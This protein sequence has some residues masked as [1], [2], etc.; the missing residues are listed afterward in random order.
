MDPHHIRFRPNNA[1]SPTTPIRRWFRSIAK[2]IKNPRDFCAFLRQTL[3]PCYHPPTMFIPR[4]WAK[5]DARPSTP[6]DGPPQVSCWK[7]SNISLADAQQRAN[8]HIVELL[9]KL[10]GG[11]PLDH[12]QYNYRPLR[13][14]IIQ[15]I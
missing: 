12:Y 9:K 5:A 2:T 15:T 8:T 3:N 11:L 4:F 14:E 1:P 6:C 10:T 7:W 13:E